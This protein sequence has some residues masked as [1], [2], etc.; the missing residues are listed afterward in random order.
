M[1]KLFTL[2]VALAGVLALQAKTIYLN[3]G[4]SSLWNQGGA[5][6]FT[7]SWGSGDSDDKMSHLSG[8]N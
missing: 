3:G 8:Y 4:G 1:K 5:V 2:V 7:H 6:F